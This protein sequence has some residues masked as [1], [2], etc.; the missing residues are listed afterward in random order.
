MFLFDEGWVV[1]IG[2]L[3]VYYRRDI[4]FVYCLEVFENGEVI[5]FLFWLY[6]EDGC[7]IWENE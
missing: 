2:F 7:Y 1:V 6:N 3:K 5:G 4:L